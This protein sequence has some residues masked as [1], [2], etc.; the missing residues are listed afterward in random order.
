M[1]RMQAL[2]CDE[3]GPI[4]TSIRLGEHPAPDAPGPDDVIV[5]VAYASVSHAMGLMIEGRYQTRPPRPFVPGTEAVGTVVAC[6]TNVIRLSPGD[7]VVAVAK[8]GCYAERLQLPQHTVYRI[9]DGLSLLDALPV[10]ISYGTAYAALMW[11][12]A[13]T[14]GETVLVLGA[15]AGVGLAAVELASLLGARVIACASTAAKREHAL[16]CGAWQAIHP[17]EELAAR[18]K[19]I[20]GGRGA[21]IVVDPVGGSLFEAATR[22]VAPN[23]RMLSIGFASGT[24]PAVPL[25]I[26]LVKNVTLHALFF[27][28]Y[29]GWTPRDERV[30]HADAMQHAVETMLGWACDGR[31]QPKVSRVYPLAELREALA[32]L[33]GR[34][35]VGKVALQ[36]QQQ[37]P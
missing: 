35:V 4:E 14:P 3:F 30:Q 13:M 10:P 5:D 2:V 9:P 25:N 36:I 7:R 29:V 28:R 24:V 37:T 20:T 12:A 18:V 16:S 31:I 11:R 21:D 1:S 15:G 26:L 23:G 34:Q 8:W 33:K 6:G 17:D 32:A 22:A 27:G 19:Q